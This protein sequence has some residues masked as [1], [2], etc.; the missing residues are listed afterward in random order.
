MERYQHLI[1]VETHH[2]DALS[3]VNNIVY[4]Q[5]AEQVA[6]LHSE[7]LGISLQSFQQLDAAMAARRH[8]LNYLAACFLNDKIQLNTWLSANDGLNLYR[9]YE[10]IRLKDHK[11]VF[12]GH[13]RWVC[14]RLST[15][16]PIRMPDAFRKAYQVN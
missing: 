10:F 16:R 4:L 9:E 6:W 15:G 11:I 14:I 1:Q 7:Q 8:E 5:W 12:R 3:H 13:T 2:L